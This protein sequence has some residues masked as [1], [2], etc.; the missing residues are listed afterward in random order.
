MQVTLISLL[1]FVVLMIFSTLHY[2]TEM[3][4]MRTEML[5]TK[6]NDL[7]NTISS[8]SSE[9]LQHQSGQSIQHGID[10][11]QPAEALDDIIVVDLQSQVIAEKIF[12]EFNPKLDLSYAESVQNSSELAT[13]LEQGVR[14]SF[15][16]HE[17]LVVI[18]PILDMG[19]SSPME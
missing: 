19:K 5:T 13:A 3:R 2:A 18:Y 6:A 12:D 8:F 1:A 15:V 14:T 9:L 16:D 11:F 17:H 10:Q 4:D 7:A